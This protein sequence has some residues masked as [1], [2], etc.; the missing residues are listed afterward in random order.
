MNIGKRHIDHIV[1]AVPNLEQACDKL[2]DILEV[3]PVFGGYHKTIGTK[4][5]L[6][7]LGDKCYLEILAIDE[8][9]ELINGPRW[10]GVDFLENAQITRWAINSESLLSDQQILRQYNL[11]MGEI[12]A[13]SRET[14]SGSLLQWEMILP[15]ALPKIELAPFMV[16]WSPSSIHPTEALD[17]KCSLIGIDFHQA[18]SDS[19]KKLFESLGIDKQIQPS[20]ES[21]IVIQIKTPSG[22]IFS[23][24]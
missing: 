6:V 10:M 21:K 14:P 23:L 17:D 2:E 18:D 13:G 16:N 24:S 15:L 11:N 5:A 7:N 19:T 8:Q 1:Y 4:N 20:S 3:K 22:K 9:N 12:F